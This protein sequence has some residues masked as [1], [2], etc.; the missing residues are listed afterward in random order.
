MSIAETK[1]D[2]R[3]HGEVHVKTP[4]PKL[5]VVDDSPEW[6][7]F[8]QEVAKRAG[9]LAKAATNHSDCAALFRTELPDVLVLDIFMP[10]WDGIE[11]MAQLEGRDDP[12]L[13]MLISGKSRPFLESARKLGQAKGLRIVG[14]LVKPMRLAELNEMLATAKQIVDAKTKHGGMP[15]T[16]RS[17]EP[18]AASRA[19]GKDALERP[20]KQPWQQQPL[21]LHRRNT[22]VS[23]PEGKA[24]PRQPIAE[25]NAHFCGMLWD[26]QRT[27][28]ATTSSVCHQLATA[29]T[30]LLADRA[31]TE[32]A[33]QWRETLG[34][35]LQ[36]FVDIQKTARQVANQHRLTEV[37]RNVDNSIDRVSAITSTIIA[38]DITQDAVYNEMLRNVKEVRAECDLLKQSFSVLLEAVEQDLKSVNESL[39]KHDFKPR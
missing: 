37:G 33:S 8:V 21:D 12:P 34:L 5:V 3:A 11:I 13:V 31:N 25:I 10:E 38:S 19:T 4:K 29:A 15:D 1:I 39:A 18:I 32:T 27:A 16:P 24:G 23:F 7:E 6:A 2:R 26:I 28:L 36:S 17:G 22:V 20:E 30:G 9:F 35:H 14:S